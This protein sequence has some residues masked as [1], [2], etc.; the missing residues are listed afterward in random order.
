MHCLTLKKAG[1]AYQVCAL[2]VSVHSLN[3]LSQNNAHHGHLQ[4]PFGQYIGNLAVIRGSVPSI[5]SIGLTATRQHTP[6][7][8]ATSDRK[9]LT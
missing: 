8:H 2:T 1:R 9:G 4:S 6:Q 5:F 7:R 3:V